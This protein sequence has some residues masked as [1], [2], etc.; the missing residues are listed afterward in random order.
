MAEG[1]QSLAV[2]VRK[3]TLMNEGVI[4][5]TEEVVFHVGTVKATFVHTAAKDV[6]LPAFVVVVVADEPEIAPHTLL[7]NSHCSMNSVWLIWEQ[8]LRGGKRYGGTIG[9]QEI[10]VFVAVQ[11]RLVR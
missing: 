6:L 8:R 1:F 11:E 10:E 9:H 2:V 4:K 5:Q 3:S 7:S